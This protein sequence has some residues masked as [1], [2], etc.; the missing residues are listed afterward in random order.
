MEDVLP[1]QGTIQPLSEKARKTLAATLGGLALLVGASQVQNVEYAGVQYTHNDA[2]ISDTSQTNNTSVF[3]QGYTTFFGL[4]NH[5]ELNITL[6][7]RAADEGVY[8]CAQDWSGKKWIDSSVIKDTRTYLDGK[9][10]PST[11]NIHARCEQAIVAAGYVSYQS[12]CPTGNN[13][14]LCKEWNK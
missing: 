8:S 6:E 9:E 12:L 3:V 13:N 1:E 11:H 4:R 5:T 14:S 2:L 7:K 10:I